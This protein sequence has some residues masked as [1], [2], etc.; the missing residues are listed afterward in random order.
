MDPQRA[1]EAPTILVVVEG[2]GLRARV[3][4]VVFELGHHLATCTWSTLE[5]RLM[6]QPKP[7]AA[8]VVAAVDESD[9]FTALTAVRRAGLELPVVMVA[10]DPLVR[11]RLASLEPAAFTASPDDLAE[12]LSAA[13]GGVGVPFACSA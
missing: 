11:E 1:Y 10:C 9:A 4:P 6:E 3:A 2:N 5:R 7:P 12:V 8:L 13:V